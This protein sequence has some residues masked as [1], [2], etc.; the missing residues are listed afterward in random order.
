MFDIPDI[1][2]KEKTNPTS[3]NHSNRSVEIFEP[4]SLCE[5]HGMILGIIIT[6]RVLAFSMELSLELRGE[7]RWQSA[8]RDTRC[9]LPRNIFSWIFYP[10]SVCEME[11]KPGVK[12]RFSFWRAKDQLYSPYVCGAETQRMLVMMI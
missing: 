4:S 12:A 9:R 6:V 10:R 2:S 5:Q 7:T 1:V 3:P 8:L 11:E